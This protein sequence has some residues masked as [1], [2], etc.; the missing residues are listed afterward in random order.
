MHID[1]VVW[2]DTVVDKILRKHGVPESDVEE[3]LWNAPRFRWQEKGLRAGED[4]YAA[5]G[6]SDSGRY[7]VIF[8]ILKAEHSA[9]V[10]SARDMDSKERRH[11]GRK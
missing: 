10:V 5:Y 7:L 9:L 6:R 4:V 11:Y 2:L 8:F 3:V 1:E